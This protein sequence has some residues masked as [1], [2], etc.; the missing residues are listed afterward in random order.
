M[1]GVVGLS[2][3]VS[4]SATV[5]AAVLGIPLAALM[6]LWA[7]PGRGA[8]IVSVNALLGL[9]P[10]VVGLALYLLLSAS[11]PLG[12]LGLLFTPQAMVLAQTLLAT[13]IIAALAH[14]AFEAAWAQFGG[15]LRVFGA[16]RLRAIPTLIA[17]CRRALVTAVLAGF[18][19]TVSEVG[20][21]LIVGGNIAGFT[22][23]MTTSIALE[24]DMGNLDRA[25]AIG[26]VL[27]GISLAASTCILAL[28]D[29]AEGGPPS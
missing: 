15:A 20:A 22:R 27:V 9:P 14:R 21:V 24:T 10:V 7:F 11:G 4:V 3:S 8:L 16:T 19:R 6:A 18:G 28:S 1:G 5:F 25:L 2:L 23:T 12:R 26:L 13:P 29:R 17:L